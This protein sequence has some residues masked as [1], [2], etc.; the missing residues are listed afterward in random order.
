M[1]VYDLARRELPQDVRVVV[2]G[3]DIDDVLIGRASNKFLSLPRI[4][5]GD[6]VQFFTGDF[7]R[8]TSE[9]S[10]LLTP[11]PDFNFIS[12]YSTTMWVHLNGGTEG[13]KAFL[14]SMRQLTSKS[15]TLLVE[16]Q[17]KKSYKTAAKR[18]R[19]MG[20]VSPHKAISTQ[21]IDGLGPTITTLLGPHF[22]SF[23]SLG[24]ESWGRTLWLFESKR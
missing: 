10:D 24:N 16:P 13:L 3:V 18:L 23:R 19:K 21:D 2:R 6:D 22:E 14:D 7:T 5:P 9:L 8:P 12:A 15:G 17:D 11:F 1:E 4:H 20:I